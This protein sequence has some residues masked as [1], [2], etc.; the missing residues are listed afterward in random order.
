MPLARRP[1]RTRAKI[2]AA[3]IEHYEQMEEDQFDFHNYCMR[4]MT[5]RSYVEM[6]KQEDAV[7]QTEVREAAWR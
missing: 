3:V 5:L 2:F 4:K 1:T 6:L 7:R